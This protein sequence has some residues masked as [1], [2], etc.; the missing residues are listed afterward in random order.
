MPS[1][2]RLGSEP[3]CQLG[4]LLDQRWPAWV[5]HR[6]WFLPLSQQGQHSRCAGAPPLARRCSTPAQGRRL[7]PP[8]MP[9]PWERSRSSTPGQHFEHSAAT[10]A[11]ELFCAA[12]AG[13]WLH[14][15]AHFSGARIVDQSIKRSP[16]AAPPRKTR[17]RFPSAP[18]AMLGPAKQSIL[19]RAIKT[20]SHSNQETGELQYARE[21]VGNC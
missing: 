13:R 17:R 21:Q 12:T 2:S 16:I 4:E 20:P 10:A 19:L 14:H 6:C 11:D 7:L 18:A 9:G 1:G 3:G 5:C 8:W 15:P